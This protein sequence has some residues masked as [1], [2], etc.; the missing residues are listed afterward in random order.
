MAFYPSRR[1]GLV[2]ELKI[3]GTAL[4]EETLRLAA[5]DVLGASAGFALLRKHGRYGPVLPNAEVWESRNRRRLNKLYLAH[6]AL[7]PDPAYTNTD[8][9]AVRS[10]TEKQETP[11]RDRFELARLKALAADMDA[12]YIRH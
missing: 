3:S 7:T 4:G 5:D 6:I 8:V 12:R 2:A 11:N 1:E 9:L 10:T